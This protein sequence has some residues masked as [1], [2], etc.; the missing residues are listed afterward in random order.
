MKTINT[1]L[2]LVCFLLLAGCKLPNDGVID[3]AAPPHVDS[4]TVSPN[5]WDVPLRGGIDTA[6][7]LEDT[8][9]VRAK[10]RVDSLGL[11]IAFVRCNATAPDGT[12]L[13]SD[14]ELRDDGVAP[15]SIA[16]DGWYTCQSTLR[17]QRSNLGGYTFRVAATDKA[18]TKSN[19]AATSFLMR[20]KNYVPTL[21]TI[22]VPDTIIVPAAG[23][24]D[25]VR[26][27][28]AVQDTNGLDD[29]ATVKVSIIRED[30]SVS[31]TF[32]MYDDGGTITYSP[33][34]LTSG[35][36][37]AGDGVYSFQ[38]P[39]LST[40]TRGIYRDFKFVAV[41]HSG[42]ESAPKIKRAYFQ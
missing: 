19:D 32:D 35:D 26:V 41:D 28:V 16:H 9:L 36:A 24:M 2:I 1:T 7:I 17:T 33:Y 40:T 37:I 6:S 14:Q 3:V 15:D 23:K 34:M 12:L 22:V 30:G 27:T 42:A 8:I 31:G 25:S 5:I 20:T 38:F 21:G 11:P 39:V 10:I 13:L 4:L 18:G 29:I